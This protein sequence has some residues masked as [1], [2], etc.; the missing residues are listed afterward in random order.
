[1]E[2]GYIAAYRYRYYRYHLEG[3]PVV[4]GTSGFE[5]VNNSDW[6]TDAVTSEEAGLIQGTSDGT[7]TP[8]GEATRAPMLLSLC[9]FAS[10]L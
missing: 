10:M 5:D 6:Y 4:T 3:S 7:L 1:M 2:K 9:V 8:Q